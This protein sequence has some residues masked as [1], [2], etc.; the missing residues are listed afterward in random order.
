MA[1]P[2]DIKARYYLDAPPSEVFK[3]LTEP[4]KLAKWF[5]DDARFEPKEGST[6]EFFWKGYPSQKG[7]VEKVVVDRLLVLTWPNTVKAKV[8][9]TKVSFALSRKGKGTILGLTHTG[10]GEGDDWVWLYGAIQAGW[11]YSLTNLKSVLSEGVDLR[12]KHDAP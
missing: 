12:S 10:F 11:A 4:K 6:Y 7:K 5:L 9:R 8:Y 2:P 1:K 3:A